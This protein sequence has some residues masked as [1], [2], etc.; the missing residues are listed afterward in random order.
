MSAWTSNI[1]R[2]EKIK[3]QDPIF[4]EHM[5]NLAKTIASSKCQYINNHRTGIFDDESITDEN[6]ATDTIDSITICQQFRRNGEL[7]KSASMKDYKTSSHPVAWIFP[8]PYPNLFGRTKNPLYL[9]N[10]RIHL[11]MS[12]TGAA[13]CEHDEV[14]LWKGKVVIQKYEFG[15]YTHEE[16]FSLPIDIFIETMLKN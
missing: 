9:Q 15:F 8:G 6:V 1:N 14:E 11:T 12:A 7:F 10:G 16:N 3:I 2:L 13:L 4:W 5:C